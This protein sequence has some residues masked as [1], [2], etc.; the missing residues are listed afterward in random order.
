MITTFPRLLS[1]AL[2][3]LRDEGPVALA[4]RVFRTFGPLNNY[5]SWIKKYDALTERDRDAIGRRLQT[6]PHQPLI[7]VLM[8]SYNISE[9]WLRRAI[10]SVLEQLYSHWELCIAD[11][12]STLP[13]VR[14]VLNEYRSRDPRIKVVFREQNGHISAA[15]NSALEL[16]HGEF[17]AL[18]DADDE[19]PEHALYMVIEELNRY[20]EADLLYSDEDKINEHGKRYGAFFK[21]DWNP[22]LFHSQNFISHLGVYRTAWV[23]RVGGFRLG[24]EGSQDYDLALR[25]IEQIPPDNIR[26]IPHVL[27]HWRALST[28]TALTTGI[29]E[30][31]ASASR[32]ALMAHF[33]RQGVEVDVVPLGSCCHRVR[34]SPPASPPL[35]SLIVPV[36]DHPELLRTCV[37]SV[38]HRTDYAHFEMVIVDNQTVDPRALSLLSELQEDPRVRVM[39]YDASFN[40]SSIV[41]WGV[42]QSSGEILCLLNNDIRV[43]SSD[44]LQEMVNHSVRPEIGAVG[45]ML[46]YPTGIVQHAGVILGVGGVAAHAHRG[47]RKGGQGYFARAALIQ[48]FSAVTAACMAMRRAVFDSVGGFDGEQLPVAFSDVDLC[49]RIRER[50]YR[51]L[52][53]P[54]AQLIHH[55]SASRGPDHHPA[56]QERFKREVEYMKS[57]WGP[58]LTNDPCYNPNLTLMREDFSLAFPSR[59]AKPWRTH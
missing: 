33:E 29:K 50:G 58:V 22:D 37:Q 12:A 20:P 18:M 3:I 41:N 5:N 16:A 45:A 38:L 10:D 34:Y 19:L 52:W 44:W 35:V 15:S 4:H 26:H 39:K 48:N 43:I 2:R 40:Y 6:L 7:S 59:A 23:R 25:I 46:Y 11:D 21:P 13:Q 27:Y 24:F 54:Y 8:P 9:R 14:P 30:Y 36:R 1:R 56:N 31:A 57:R 17:V 55:E 28:S 53:T 51:I 32:K 49:L 42:A 47:L